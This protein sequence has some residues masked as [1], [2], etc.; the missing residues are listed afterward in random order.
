M[1]SG[2]GPHE[3]QMNRS[4]KRGLAISLL[5]MLFL[6]IAG[7]CSLF[8]GKKNPPTAADDRGIETYIRKALADDSLLKS[9]Q[10]VV[11]SADGIVELTGFVGS[12]GAKS[13]A[14]LVAASTP[15]V[16]QVH[17]DVLVRPA[18]AK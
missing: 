2:R 10:F 16:V 18:S 14:G 17:N 7:G 13:R 8:S 15:G 3:R 11:H 12:I 9:T 1:G 5:G 6:S 4:F